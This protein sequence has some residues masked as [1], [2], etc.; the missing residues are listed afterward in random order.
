MLQYQQSRHL[1]AVAR[2]SA[3]GVGD[4]AD[5]KVTGPDQTEERRDGGKAQISANQA[6]TEP[7]FNELLLQFADIISC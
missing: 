2:S 3:G 5:L 4:M 7:A 1:V 6:S